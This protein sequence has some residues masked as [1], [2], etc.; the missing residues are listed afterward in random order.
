[1]DRLIC[2]AFPRTASTFLTDCLSLAFP[3]ME[4]HHIFHKIEI[5]RTESNIVT[6]LRKPEDAISS[7]LT[8]V[9]E[10]DIEGHLDWYNRFMLAILDRISEVFI[11]TYDAII[12][13]VNA[14]IAKCAEFYSLDA[15]VTVDAQNISHLSTS[16][17]SLRDKVL[18]SPNYVQ[19]LNLYKQVLDAA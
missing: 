5:L 16:N 4:I 3:K 12:S 13:D 7:W 6:I 10:T 18:Q 2:V 17:P 1:M 8:K 9:N 15:P 19:S 14:V 11:T